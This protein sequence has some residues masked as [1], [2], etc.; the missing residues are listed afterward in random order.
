VPRPS[1]S[2]RLQPS[3]LDR[4]T[5]SDPANQEASRLQR[6]ITTRALREIVIRDLLAL[7]NTVRFDAA[8][9]DL[10]AYPETAK[11]VVNFGIPDLAGISASSV[12]SE[13]LGR[14]VRE[15][16][17]AF[18]PRLN[19]SSLKVRAI[20]AE[21]RMAHNTLVFEIEGE[22]WADPSPLRLLVRTELDLETGKVAIVDS[23]S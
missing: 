18:E 14:A 2:G 11:S 13:A 1:Q 23:A 5:D 19:C 22:L 6:V 3:L 20:L 10:S 17:V 12:D 4:L 9:R 7:L 8:T 21:D 16:V 15:A